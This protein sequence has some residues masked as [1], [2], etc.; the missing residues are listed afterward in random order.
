MSRTGS[1]AL[2]SIALAS[3]V[4]SVSWLPDAASAAAAGEDGE[5]AV[6]N[7]SAD[8]AP[9]LPATPSDTVDAADAAKASAAADDAALNLADAVPAASAPSPAAHPWK[10]FVQDA[11]R[12]SGYRDAPS[13]LRNQ[14]SV[15]LLYQQAIVPSVSVNFSARFDRF[16][17]LSSSAAPHRSES[18]IREAFASWSVTP[19]TGVD[20]G[21]I[22]E[23]LG[24]A[25]G[26]NPTDFFKAGAVN[27]DVSPDPESRRT[28][29]LGTVGVRA[30]HL[31]D[32]GSAQFLFSPRLASYSAPGNPFASS[33]LKRTNGVNRWLFVGSQRV[34]ASVQP[35]LL[36][37]GE[38]GQS[39]Q[40]GL[41]LSVVPASSVVA[42]AEW[43]GGRRAS[44][45]GRSTGVD[46]RAFRTSSAIGATWTT[47]LDLSIT[48]ELQSNGAGATPSQWRLLQS[49][50]PRAWGGAVQT[51]VASQDL[52][53]RHGA[54]VMAIWR[55]VGVRRLD[56][57]AFVQ[58]DQGGGRQ[59]WLELRRHYDRFDVA[60]QLQRQGGPSWNRYGAM[61]E[62]RSVQMVATFYE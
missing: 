14:L 1:R 8:E 38:Q 6:P 33:D 24:A 31:W 32:G 51:G 62:S 13:S 16:D 49:S 30:Q 42:Y 54:F 12:E 29:R 41:N 9:A 26:Y 55:N 43:T 15:D 53:T 4:A 61:P 56:L 44:L 5:A 23:R 25:V 28:N 47:P 2:T 59:A 40:V 20:A 17:P 27:L 48:A 34:S 37:Y 50:D 45:I 21:R 39:P 19:L 60:L 10:F 52:P 18:T 22:N 3:L 46:D 11:V 36:M 35:Q 57:S 58:A 7:D